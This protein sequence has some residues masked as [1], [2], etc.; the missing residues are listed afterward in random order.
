M[1]LD[2]DLGRRLRALAA[3]VDDDGELGDEARER[4]LSAVRERGPGLVR[5][6]RRVDLA[7]RAG[8]PVVAA[9]AAALLLVGM[10]RD[11]DPVE[12][13]G[14]TTGKQAAAATSPACAKSPEMSSSGFR[15]DGAAL[16][17]DLGSRALAVAPADAEV[18]LSEL[19]RCRTVIGLSR[20]PVTVHAKDLGGGE[21]WVVAGDVQVRVVGTV[22]SVSRTDD[23]VFVEVAEG[24]VR[25]HRDRS[26]RVVEAGGRLML[27][28]VGVATGRLEA[29]R[30]AALRRAV[31]LPEVIGLD[32]LEPEPVLAPSAR[33]AESE[34][35]A[36]SH[37][38]NRRGPPAKPDPSAAEEAP[39]DEPRVEPVELHE[40]VG[41]LIKEAEDARRR[42]DHAGARSLYR[43]A[44]SRGGPTAEAAWLALAR[45]ELSLGN[46][47][48]AREA[49]DER[50]QRFGRG[51]LGPEAL[52]IEVRID[53]SLGD[54][55][56][57][58][59]IAQKLVARWPSSP[60]AA[61]ARRWLSEP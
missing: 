8:A 30:V 7:W 27:S 55:A 37:L 14:P 53:R 1:T 19:E 36:R 3:Q 28:R 26:D 5:R 44:G 52:W 32:T 41:E 47:A 59:R 18:H 57:A 17:L 16:R 58:R 24:R 2:G 46:A 33:A 40:S 45:M 51:T 54:P 31:G 60:Q 56:R 39:N 43:R 20:G 11:P 42:G 38:D 12:R 61:A 10:S 29:G 9:A 22:F 6:A 34:A 50:Q 49:I 25:V 23:G 48:A 21:L 35:P 13:P 15:S 4:I